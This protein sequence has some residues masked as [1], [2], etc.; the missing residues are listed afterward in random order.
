MS[1]ET[2]T[3]SVGSLVDENL[4]GAEMETEELLL[5]RL[6]PYATLRP[7]DVSLLLGLPNQSSSSDHSHRKLASLF[8]NV[9]VERG[10]S[11]SESDKEPDSEGRDV[12]VRG[13]DI[14]DLPVQYLVRG[15]R[16]N[17]MP[18][19][20]VYVD[21]KIVPGF[22]YRIRRV[23]TERYLFEGR[24]LTLQSVGLGYGK[25]LTFAGDS[26]NF[27]DNY[28]WSDSDP[29]G[30]AFSLDAVHLG[31][32]MMV[33]GAE[34]SGVIGEVKVVRVPGVQEEISSEV[35]NGDII[36]RARVTL[37]C[38][39]TYYQCQH[40]RVNLK[41][42]DVERM[43]GE[44]IVVKRKKS[45]AAVLDCIHDVTLACVPGTCTLQVDP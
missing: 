28:F 44:A 13:Q 6:S 37:E 11:D 38:Q 43:T 31:H 24:A 20:G 33:Y 34:G 19:I 36:K 12:I 4:F 7:G 10:E 41:L 40:G 29:N 14:G 25:R 16:P 30:F 3:S 8:D 22:R 2:L 39:V 18:V 27:N 17:E 32:Q 42:H 5:R 35:V 9:I 1:M 23:G 45:R 26:L 15:L 21:P